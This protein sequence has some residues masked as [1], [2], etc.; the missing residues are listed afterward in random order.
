MHELCVIGEESCLAGPILYSTNPFI[1]LDICR[2][3]RNDFHRVW[4]SEVFDP[5]TLAT[6]T[7][8]A[9]VAPSS[10]PCAL[11]NSLLAE[12][13]ME[14]RHSAHRKRYRKVFRRLAATWAADGSLTAAQAQ[15]V[16]DMVKQVSFRIWKPFVYI[17]PREPIEA[18]ERLEMV[19]VSQRAGH[20]PEFR[21]ADLKGREF[22]VMEWK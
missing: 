22:D 11:A 6:N 2:V 20:G 17:I 10:S 16:R 9:M 15:D 13:E 3:F 21:I 12:M 1:S 7:R 8:G 18:M 19:P 14:D 4:C 5:T